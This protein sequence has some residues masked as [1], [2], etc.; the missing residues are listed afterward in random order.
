MCILFCALCSVTGFPF[1][2]LVLP[3][4]LSCLS[5]ENTLNPGQGGVLLL[6]EWEH[7]TCGV[8]I[9]DYLV[10]AWLEKGVSSCIPNISLFPKWTDLPIL[11]WHI[12]RQ[13]PCGI[14]QSE[15][16]LFYHFT[17]WESMDQRTVGMRWEKS[18]AECSE[19]SLELGRE[20]H[21][22]TAF[23]ASPCPH[24]WADTSLQDLGKVHW[25]TGRTTAPRGLRLLG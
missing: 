10:S 13:K 25:S 18:L 19:P 22:C 11:K 20:G 8:G 16:G 2:S 14:I 17:L 1:L 9:C 15:K 21:C 7:T 3:W 23:L 6:S 24:L 12:F 5:C 4:N